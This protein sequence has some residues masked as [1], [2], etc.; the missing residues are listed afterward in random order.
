MQNKFFVG[1][2]TSNYTTSVAVLD[3]DGNILYNF[4]QLLSVKDN[5]CGLRQSDAL[6]AH[7]KNLPHALRALKSFAEKGSIAAVGVSTRPRNIEGSYMPCFLAGVN[8]AEAIASATGVPL[9]EFSHQC[10]HIMAAIKS[11]ERY[12]LLEKDFLAFHISGGTTEM[13]CVKFVEDAFVCDIVGGTLDLSAGQAVDRIGVDMG[14]PFP[15]GAYMEQLA[16]SFEGKI[17]NR[18]PTMNG[19]YVNLSGLENIAKKMYRD[20]QSREL[21]C[22]FVFKYISRMLREMTQ[23]YYAQHGELP[24]IFAGGVMSCSLIKNELMA[25][26]DCGFAEP[27][28]SS[29]N[30]VG[31]AELARRKYISGR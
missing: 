2:D 13:L 24:V 19:T 9:Y 1:V 22:A 10:G 31:I 6:F 26:F 17:P 21:V 8:A 15:A 12:D 7:I 3:E 5:E 14:L 11:S 30:A 20:T 18:K 16:L 27:K 28:L 25:Q 4:K 29:D 23:S